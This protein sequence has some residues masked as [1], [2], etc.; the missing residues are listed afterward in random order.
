M[1]RARLG[2][3]SRKDRCV[4]SEER[5]TVTVV[6]RDFV[7]VRSSFHHHEGTNDY[8]NSGTEIV[9]IVTRDGESV[10]PVWKSDWTTLTA[11]VE[12]R[13]DGGTR[14]LR[15]LARACPVRVRL[16]NFHEYVSYTDSEHCSSS[17]T[18]AWVRYVQKS[19]ASPAST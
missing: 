19:D 13:D 17:T 11:G 10:Q 9:E 8:T 1:I 18:Y 6:T 3:V 15:I 12:T 14:R 4:S 7:E 2:L 16:R 5:E